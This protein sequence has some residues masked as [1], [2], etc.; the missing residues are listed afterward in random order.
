MNSNHKVNNQKV[1]RPL[2]AIRLK[3]L[4]CSSWSWLEVK[5]CPHDSCILHP[6]RYGRKPKKVRFQTVTIK[7]YEKR[8]KNS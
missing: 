5:E 4:D 6:F 7:E 1:A 3:C 8:I 2:K